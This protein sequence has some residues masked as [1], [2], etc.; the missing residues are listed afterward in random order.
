MDDRIQHHDDELEASSALCDAALAERAIDIARPMLE[1]A[2][3]DERLGKSGYLHLVIMNPGCP[4]AYCAFEEA[5]LR[6][7]T[8]G[9]PG[10][11]P[12]LYRRLAREK[13]RLSWLHGLDTQL[14]QMRRA[15]V[16]SRGDVA[17]WGSVAVEGIVVAISGLDAWYDEALSGAVA[18]CLRGVMK[19]RLAHERQG[20]LFH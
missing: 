15:H 4:P 1:R 8:C 18:M 5:I 17:L 7:W 19:D 20:G 16:L 14:L 3:A 2:V 9:D 6:E 11:Q 12:E 10:G 13:A